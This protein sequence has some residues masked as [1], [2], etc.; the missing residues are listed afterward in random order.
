MFYWYEQVLGG[1][2]V[3]AI[4][5]FIQLYVL[6]QDIPLYLIQHFRSKNDS[7]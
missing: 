6:K 7:K 3:Y 2:I 5:N 4:I 1:L